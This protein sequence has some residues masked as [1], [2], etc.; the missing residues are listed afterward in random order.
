MLVAH[1]L[2]EIALGHAGAAGAATHGST[3]SSGAS[4]PAGGVG[5][6]AATPTSDLLRA[7]PL[8]EHDDA[9]RANAPA[10]PASLTLQQLSPAVRDAVRGIAAVALQ[11]ARSGPVAEDAA[12]AAAAAWLPF[13]TQAA[14]YPWLRSFTKL[15]LVAAGLDAEAA[16]MGLTELPP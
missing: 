2:D 4:Q 15:G 8:V 7:L 16:A 12:P 13:A 5:G 1:V 3:S 10:A 11:R 14:K 6:G 9:A